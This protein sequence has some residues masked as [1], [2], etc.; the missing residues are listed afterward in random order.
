VSAPQLLAIVLTIPLLA[1]SSDAAR[2]APGAPAGQPPDAAVVPVPADAA[3]AL[4]PRPCPP[5]EW[6]DVP[7]DPAARGPW[8]VG[9]RTLELAG[10]RVEV[11]Y[12]AAPGS[13]AKRA[14]KT[15]DL[16]EHL[17]ATEAAKVPDAANPPQPCDCFDALPLDEAHGPYPVVVFFHGVASF[18]TQSAAFNTH[19]AS[20][21][22]VVIAPQ[23]PQVGLKDILGERQPGDPVKVARGVL[24]AVRDGDAALAFLAGHVQ[25][26]GLAVAGHSLGSGMAMNV[27]D[28]PGVEAVLLL[29][30]G[31][32]RAPA[33]PVSLLVMGGTSDGVVPWARQQKVH[34]AASGEGSRAVLARLVGLDKA[35]HLAFSDICAVGR[36]QGG[37]LAVAVA[38]GVKMPGMLVGLGQDG[39]GQD[40]MPP[41]TAHPIV[42]A[43]TTAVLEER[44]LCRPPVKPA[45]A[46]STVAETRR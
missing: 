10:T 34:A 13:E 44:L 22:F 42:N 39:C 26:D 18:R 4:A 20:R 6:L 37:M 1:C 35:G 3:V 16:R 28:E 40:A 12:P 45:L 14:R 38:H 46:G 23:L 19:W 24:A 32:P 2:R 33:R 21:G 36:D 5:V 8:P 30:P 11:F 17:P 43:H 25:K 15:Y 29:S 27:M 7:A 31:Q 41:E 9:A